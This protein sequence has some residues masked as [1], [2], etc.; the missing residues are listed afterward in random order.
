MRTLLPFGHDRYL[1]LSPHQ[2]KNLFQSQ[3]IGK[4]KMIPAFPSLDVSPGIRAEASTIPPTAT[5][6]VNNINVMTPRIIRNGL[7]FNSSSS[8]FDLPIA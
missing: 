1:N 4:R 5:T 8:Q 2:M 3:S 7:G 6:I